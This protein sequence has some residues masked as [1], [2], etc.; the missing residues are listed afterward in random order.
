MS[1]SSFRLVVDNEHKP[2][3]LTVQDEY[4]LEKDPVLPHTFV[5][6]ERAVR[7][8]YERGFNFMHFIRCHL[9]M[10]DADL[11]DSNVLL[12]WLARQALAEE[13]ANIVF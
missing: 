8:C 4:F 12:D 6:R 11:I 7:Q 5:T 10:S 2:V 1:N 9:E 3:L 13:F